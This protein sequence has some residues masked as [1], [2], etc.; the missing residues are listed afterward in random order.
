M[1][2]L[3]IASYLL[4]SVEDQARQLGAQRVL[5]INLVAGERAGIVDEALQFSFD[6]LTAETL[7]EGARINVRRTFMCFHCAPCDCEYSPKVGDFN[8]P[9]CGA[10]GQL[11]ADGTELLIESI[12]IET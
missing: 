5:A 3:S 1:H 11:T 7:A 2:E 6:L 9:N 4:D 8:C 10:V 12:E